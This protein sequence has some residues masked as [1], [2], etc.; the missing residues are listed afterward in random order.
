MKVSTKWLGTAL[1]T[2]KRG[3][4]QAIQIYRN[5][6]QYREQARVQL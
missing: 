4:V 5:S 6:T 1:G 2:L 3:R